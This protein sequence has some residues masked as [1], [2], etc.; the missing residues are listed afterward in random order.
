MKF[1]NLCDNMYYIKLNEGD[2]SLTNYCRHCGNED[3]SSDMNIIYSEKSAVYN[4][5]IVNEFTKYDPTLPRISNIPC[6]NSECISHNPDETT[7]IIYIKYDEVN[8]KF[9]YL[10][11][12]CDTS[13]KI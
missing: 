7:E 8:L 2:M 5:D 4:K 1:C 11:T 12:K 6:Q 9:L 3:N 13:W 10:C